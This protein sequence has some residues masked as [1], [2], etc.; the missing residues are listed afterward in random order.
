MLQT[1]P[2]NKGRRSVGLRT[3]AGGGV[4]VP[5][6]GQTATKRV[7]FVIT[8]LYLTVQA[9]KQALLAAESS[10]WLHDLKRAKSYSSL[11]IHH[12]SKSTV[13][14]NNGVPFRHWRNTAAPA[15]QADVS[16]YSG[17][18]RKSLTCNKNI[19]TPGPTRGF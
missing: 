17:L 14:P 11:G 12:P 9:C 5:T 16:C 8:T 3:V 2:N 1:P 4:P 19:Q 13:G 6:I 18:Q 7:N 10:L 15:G